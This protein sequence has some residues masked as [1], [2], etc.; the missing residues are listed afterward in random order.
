MEKGKAQRSLNRLQFLLSLH[1]DIY[2]DFCI[3]LILHR[4]SGAIKLK[5][6]YSQYSL[7]KKWD[8]HIKEGKDW[9]ERSQRGSRFLGND[10]LVLS[11]QNNAVTGNAKSHVDLW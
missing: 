3:V 11:Q 6:F 10:V 7:F 4:C 5:V 9:T 8:I 2:M 1:K